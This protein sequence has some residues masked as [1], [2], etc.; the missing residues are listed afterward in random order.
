MEKLLEE[1]AS[2][3][4]KFADLL[5]NK[6]NI[7]VLNKWLKV[8][9]TYT[10]NAIEGNTLTR[11]ETSLAIEENITSGSKPINDYLEACNHAKAYDFIVDFSRKELE[12]NEKVVLQIHKLILSGIDDGNAGF[13]RSVRVRISGSSAIL[14]NA[15]KVPEL[16][17]DFS[18]WLI[19][20]TYDP[21]MKAIEAHYRLVSIHPFIEGNGRTARL[22]MN[23]ILMK[24]NYCPIIIRPIDRKRYLSCLE[25]RQTK[26]KSEPYIRFMLTALKRSLKTIINA[27]DTTNGEIDNKKLL[28]I[29]KFAELVGLPSS[30][31]RY[32]VG[33]G[34]IKPIAYRDSGY[35]LF[36][37]EQKDEILSHDT[38]SHDTPLRK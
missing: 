7:S 27:L 11:K 17:E 9:L 26:E 24:S 19:N 13:Y 18:K 35:M 12:I 23:M 36:D 10:S 30:T 33:I 34:K 16:M 20:E 5:K 1:I 37:P 15:L 31:I 2:Y 28:T 22:L 14:P 29:S 8:E 25:I 21:V 32:W 6:G 3:K 4:E 38:I